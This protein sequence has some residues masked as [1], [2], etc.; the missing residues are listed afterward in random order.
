MNLRNLLVMTIVLLFSIPSMAAPIKVHVAE[1]KV[2]GAAETANLKVALQ[3]LLTSRLSAEKLK[4]TGADDMPDLTVIGTY[5]AFGKVFSLDARVT[6]RSGIVVLTGFEQGESADDIIPAVSR[7]AKKLGT[8]ISK[9]TGTAASAPIQ[10]AAPITSGAVPATEII[11]AP[12]VIQETGETDIIKPEAATAKSAASGMISPRLEGMII[13]IAEVKRGSGG[14]REL[15]AALSDELRL[16]SQGKEL[17]LLDSMKDLAANG[18]IVALDSADLDADG[19]HELYVT[20]VQEEE[21]SSRVYQVENGRIKRIASDLP[22]F[23]RA[24]A[25]KGGQKKVYAQQMGRLEDYYGG[26]YEVVKKGDKFTLEN[27]TKLPRFANLFNTNQLV[28]RDGK[29][30]SLVIHPDNY[31]LVYDEKGELLWKS[32]DKY[33]GSET[34]FSRDDSSNQRTTGSKIRKLFLEQR[35]TVTKSGTVIIPK[36]EGYFV[37]GD[38][39]SFTKNSIYAF[40]WNGAA[41]DELWHTRLSQNYLADYFYDADNKELLVVEVVKKEGITDKGASAVSI[42]KVE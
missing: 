11:P 7:L 23:F 15:A 37:V 27:Q 18:K 35:V 21:L 13:G 4:L 41:L 40:V 31:L 25:L 20:I 1:F 2:T 38:S 26:L 29:T 17:K 6:N 5:I 16:Y 3:S 10:A 33:G 32:S 9:S 22:Y 24:I 39:R 19:T 8:E 36:N 30:L 28:D 14:E 12:A 42:K 34:Y